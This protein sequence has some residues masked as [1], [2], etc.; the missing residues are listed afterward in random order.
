MIRPLLIA[1][2]LFLL[3]VTSTAQ[4]DEICTDVGITPSLDS[5]FAHVPYVYGRVTLV[6]FD[7]VGKTP[8]VVVILSDSAHQANRYIL[9]KKGNYCFR[10]TGSGTLIVEVDGIEVARRSLQSF[11]APQLREDFEVHAKAW[12][13]GTA[14]ALI[15]AKLSHPPNKDTAELHR[16][17][18]DALKA[19]DSGIGVGLLKEIVKID[20]ADFIAWAHLGLVYFTDNS[21]AEAEAAFRKCLELKVEYTP[22]W[23]YMGQIRIAQKQYLAAIEILKHAATLESRSA[24]IYRLLGQA[25]LQSKQGTL[26]VAAL[27]E[28]IKLDPIGMAECHLQIAHLYELAGAKH[29]AAKEYKMF[30]DKVPDYHSKKRLEQFIKDN[31]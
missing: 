20:P 18:A 29:L 28:A 14:P 9:G 4:I 25:Y 15:S 10:R 2:S 24:R 7:P 26:G 11:G 22:A 6:G 3:T 16:K 13:R 21:L 30:L 19:G 12:Q 27:N 8:K 5:P 23:F 31:P 1:A 17:L